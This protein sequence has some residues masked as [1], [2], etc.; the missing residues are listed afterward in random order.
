MAGRYTSSDTEITSEKCMTRVL[1]FFI[2][3]L[4]FSAAFAVERYPFDNASQRQRFVKLTRE[5]RCLVC[6]NETIDASNAKLAADLRGQVY[7]MILDGHSNADIKKYLVD[8]Y[9]DFVLFNP[10]FLRR[11]FFL[12]LAPLLLLLMG[13]MVFFMVLRNRC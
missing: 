11:T 8:R 5:L 4:S 12:W 13:G 3:C 1:L 7:K 2:L 6:Q 9:G 10:P